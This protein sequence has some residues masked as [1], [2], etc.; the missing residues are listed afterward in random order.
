MPTTTWPLEPQTNCARLDPDSLATYHEQGYVIAPGVFSAGEITAI[1]GEI[2]RLQA[3]KPD[4]FAESGLY[5]LGLRSPITEAICRDE[6][7]L[8]LIEDIVSPGIAIYSAKMVHKPA[9]S[10]LVCHWH[11][12]NAYYNQ[13]SDSHCRMSIWLSLQDTTEANGCLWVVPG[14]H[15]GGTLPAEKRGN[16][17]CDLAFEDGGKPLPGAIPRPLGSG[18]VL[19][20]HADLWHR[21]LGNHSDKPRRSFIV[22]YQEA[23]AARGNGAQ[24]K[25]LRPA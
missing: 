3:E 2:D 6:R 8:T 1:N 7:I 21:S 14:S 24:H 17:H 12:D 16:G 4:A 13:H 10:D 11:Q 9:H 5:Q 19:L 15:K 22:S 25:I 20:F 23:T 18:D